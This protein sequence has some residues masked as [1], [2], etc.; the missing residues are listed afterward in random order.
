MRRYQDGERDFVLGKEDKLRK[1][2]FRTRLVGREE[3][4]SHLKDLFNQASDGKG[5][6]CL[7]SG[8]AGRGKTRLVEDLR[9]YVYEMGGVFLSGRCLDQVGS[10]QLSAHNLF[11]NILRE[12]RSFVLSEVP[13]DDITM[14]ILKVL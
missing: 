11:E 3:E 8:E 4:I 13:Q 1:L 14:V 6:V 5:K 2:P 7:I 10:R 9:G 12:L